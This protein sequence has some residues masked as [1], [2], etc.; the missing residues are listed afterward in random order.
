MTAIIQDTASVLFVLA[1]GYFSGKRSMFTQDQAEGFNRLVL[2]YC[3]PA[4]LFVS[5]AHSTRQQLWSDRTTLV[6]A[7]IVLMGWYLAS[8]AVA[9]FFFGHS[10]EEA[11]IAGLSASTP[12]VGFLGIAVLAPLFG[13]G[14]AL[15]VATVALVVNLVLVPL[16]VILAAPASTKLSAALMQA[17]EQPIVIAPMIATAMVAA[18]IRF[19]SVADA[20]LALIGHATSGVAVFTAGLVLAAH[21]FRLNLEVAWNVV[22][23]LVLMPASMLALG[24]A[25]GIGGEM[26][27]QL[28]LI[29]ALP[30]VFAG[31]ILAVR[32]NTYVEI[33]SSTLITN[34][35][36]FVVAAP[37]WIAVARSFGA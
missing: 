37:A 30:P 19:P 35:L 20:P 8:L 13:A 24:L 6:A 31:M 10:R 16:G 12:T 36:L 5:I 2:N 21:T 28:I 27:E 11:V 18:G 4:M 33:A 22:I 25:Y 1:L 34:T 14:A 32:Y 26:L 23:K 3:L 29:V 9:K 7:A 15:T 17:I